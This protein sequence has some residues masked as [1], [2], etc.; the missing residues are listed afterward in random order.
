MILD[1]RHLDIVLSDSIDYYPEGIVVPVDKPYRWTSAYIFRKQLEESDLILL[2]KC[3]LLSEE[4]LAEL[5]ARTSA[6]FPQAT[7]LAA[8]ALHG[9][10]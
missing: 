10:G 9:T 7:I 8:S 5:K 6:A 2:N 1:S 3:D 4:A